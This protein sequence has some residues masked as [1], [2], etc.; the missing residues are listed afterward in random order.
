MLLRPSGR[1]TPLGLGSD[2][3]CPG[4]DFPSSLRTRQ[5]LQARG[6]DFGRRLSEL[7]EAAWAGELT[8]DL[9]YVVIS[10]DEDW[11]HMTDDGDVAVRR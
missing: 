9:D 6:S 7:V 1:T 2:T 8:S 3:K 11:S 5:Q 4:A 10:R